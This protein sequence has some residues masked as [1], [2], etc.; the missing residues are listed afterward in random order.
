VIASSPTDIQPVLDT[1]AERAARLCESSDAEI[2]RRD[3]A[4]LLLVAHHG[5]IPSRTLVVP[6]IRETFN[7]RTV[8]DGRTLHIVDLQSETDE[9]PRGSEIARQHGTRAQLSVP[10]MREGVAIGTISLRRAEARLFTDRQVALLQIF[11]DQAV[12]A[13]ENVRLFT[14]TKEALE[15]QTATSEILR[16]ISSSP[17]DTQPVFDIIAANAAR[18]CAARDAQVLRVEGDVLRLVSAYGSP[19]MPPVR[20]ISRGHAV[21]RAVIDRQTVHVRDMAQ[22]IA[23]FPE[24]SAPQHGVESVLAVPLLR[25]DVAVGVI[26]ISRTQRQP[27]T[28]QQIALLQTFADQAVIAIEN[29]RLFNETKEALDRQTATAEILSVISSSPTDLQP[30]FDTIVR[31][32]VSLCGAAFGGLHQTKEGRITIDAQWGM[33]AD[34]VVMLQRHVFPLPLSRGGVTGRAI[35]D[36][37]VI[38]VRIFARTRSIAP[39]C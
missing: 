11:A 32:A 13:I 35:L 23:E 1:V 6:L 38:T 28:D 39:L 24:T 16:A 8:L 21:G 36:R 9:F 20:T 34:D 29:V 15:R 33:A 37:A 14:E 26:R 22:A 7:G 4:R 27:F 19:S 31:N 25:E 10:L 2:F 18:L 17:T 3:G 12:I 30:V 5:P